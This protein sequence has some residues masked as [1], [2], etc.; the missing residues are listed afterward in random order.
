MVWQ[1]HA[2]SAGYMLQGHT[3]KELMPEAYL[4][5]PVEQRRLVS[6]QQVLP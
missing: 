2:A 4:M 5:H 3:V 6:M 1:Q